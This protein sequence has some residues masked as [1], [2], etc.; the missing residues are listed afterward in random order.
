V[1]HEIAV[2][3]VSAAAAA[4]HDALYWPST[5]WPHTLQLMYVHVVMDNGRLA[6]M[7]YVKRNVTRHV[8][9]A[10]STSRGTSRRHVARH[11]ALYWPNTSWQH[12]MRLALAPSRD[13]T[14]GIGRHTSQHC[15]LCLERVRRKGPAAHFQRGATAVEQDTKVSPYSKSNTTERLHRQGSSQRRFVYSTDT[16]MRLALTPSRNATAGIGRHT[17]QDSTTS[18]K[19]RFVPAQNEICAGTHLSTSARLTPVSARARPAFQ[20]RSMA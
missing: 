1:C 19:L 14:A 15:P 9:T 6:L 7:Q 3:K 20:A 12:N 2:S 8:S 18:E 10:R 11:A 4:R 16:G 5:S 13:A 17:S